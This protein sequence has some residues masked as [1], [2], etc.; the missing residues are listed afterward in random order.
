MKSNAHREEI[1]WVANRDEFKLQDGEFVIVF[2][3]HMPKSWRF[4]KRKPGKRDLNAWK[5]MENRPDVDNFFK[6]LADSLCKEDRKIWCAAILKIWIPDTVEEGTYFI[7]LPDF[8][9]FCVDY[10]K[11]SLG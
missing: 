8:F 3:K 7:N 11:K 2:M 5:P 10:L 9:K 6:K 4:G 1:Q